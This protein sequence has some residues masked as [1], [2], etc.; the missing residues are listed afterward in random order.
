MD[1]KGEHAVA[2][3]GFTKIKNNISGE[4]EEQVAHPL[5]VA[6]TFASPGSAPWS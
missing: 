6:H 5:S 3:M 1:L 2:F 4:K